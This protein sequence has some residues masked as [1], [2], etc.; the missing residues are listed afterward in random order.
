LKEIDELDWILSIPAIIKVLTVFGIIVAANGLGLHLGLAA[1]AGAILIA[2]WNGLLPAD[3]VILVARAAV[4][5]DTI[6]LALV[7]GGILGLSSVMKQTGT[8]DDVVRSYR[9]LLRSPR[10]TMATLP[11]LI[12]VLPMPGG[13]VF[14]APMV[15]ALDDGVCLSQEER[16]AVNFWFR[17]TIEL[18]WPLYPAFILTSAISGLSFG[19]IIALNAYAPFVLVAEGM[20]FLLRGYGPTSAS[21]SGVRLPFIKSLGA[22]L[23]AFA[24]VLLILAVSAVLDFG[25]KMA[26]P[27]V[28][29]LFPSFP[30][31]SFGR[32]GP[33][34]FGV[35]C[36]V[37]L[38]VKTRGPVNLRSNFLTAG[39]LAMVG[40]IVGIKVFSAVL[41]GTGVADSVTKDLANMGI[42][43]IAVIALL[44]FLAGL[45]TGVGFGCIGLSFPISI[46]LI[47]AGTPPLAYGANVALAGAFGFAGMMLSPLHVCMVVTAE[48]FGT[49]IAET[50]KRV[51]VPILVFLMVAVSYY[52]ILVALA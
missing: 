21:S 30:V 23:G 34:F 37:A 11:G 40:T 47:P 41:D 6:L 2:F 12:G 15:E 3:M 44:P 1:L 8:M 18:V 42:P 43:S 25:W 50:L 48:H 45:V 10:L 22:F 17:H 14:S 35:I 36:G 51:G 24:P 52:I 19:T 20:F 26:A 28:L 38:L 33:I 46:A 7:L 31:S 27:T 49:K 39:S 29:T 4:S 32:Y 16:S 9:N 5:P 13:A